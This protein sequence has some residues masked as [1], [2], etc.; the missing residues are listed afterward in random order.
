MIF[1]SVELLLLLLFTQ[2][3][4]G[5]ILCPSTLEIVGLR[6]SVRY[7]RDFP[8]YSVCSVSNI[9]PSARCASAA[10]V[11]CRDVDVFGPKTLLLKHILY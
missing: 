6:V 2:G 10:D 5:S 11:V 8:M 9:C 4:R 3:Y 7:I 1:P